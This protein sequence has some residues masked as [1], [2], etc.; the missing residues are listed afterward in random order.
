MKTYFYLSRKRTNSKGLC[1]VYCRVALDGSNRPD[2]ST[3]IFIHP[4][5]WDKQRGCPTDNKNSICSRLA[6]ISAAIYAL[7]SDC[8][9]EE[10]YSPY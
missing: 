9:R 3:G 5:A 1:P 8:E 7:I 6:T 10:L 4:D 2:F